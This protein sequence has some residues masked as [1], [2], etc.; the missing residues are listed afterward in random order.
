M[1][2]RKG[3]GLLVTFRSMFRSIVL[4]FGLTRTFSCSTK[5]QNQ[6]KLEEFLPIISVKPVSYGEIRCSTGRG[7]PNATS[8]GGWLVCILTSGCSIR[9][10]LI[11]FGDWNRTGRSLLKQKQLLLENGCQPK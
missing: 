5:I 6:H 3:S 10:V 2:I 7:Q 4:T 1:P 9:F 11:I 8:T